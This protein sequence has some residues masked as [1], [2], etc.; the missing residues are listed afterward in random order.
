MGAE[1]GA[2]MYLPSGDAGYDWAARWV[3]LGTK[4]TA[5]DDKNGTKRE[6]WLDNTAGAA[7]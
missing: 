5:I 6:W 4:G 2:E 3:R 7:A 1:A